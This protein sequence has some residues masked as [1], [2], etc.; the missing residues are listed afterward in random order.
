[1]CVPG[2]KFS[3]HLEDVK[4]NNTL[5]NGEEEGNIKVFSGENHGTVEFHIIINK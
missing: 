5:V 1:M 4:K 3:L 2:Y